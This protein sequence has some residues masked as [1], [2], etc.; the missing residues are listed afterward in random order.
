MG[1]TALFPLRMKWC[2]VILSLFPRP[3]FNP[4][5]LSLVA[6]TLTISP[7]MTNWELLQVDSMTGLWLISSG[8]FE[9]AASTCDDLRLVLS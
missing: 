5:K 3:G 6:S 4:R 1:L 8:V 2:Y 9:I 7:P